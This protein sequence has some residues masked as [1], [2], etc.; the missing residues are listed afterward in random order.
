MQRYE[1]Y[2]QMHCKNILRG[3]KILFL[4]RGI[5][6]ISFKPTCNVLII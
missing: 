3:S 6:I 5:K 4:T 1:T 2:F